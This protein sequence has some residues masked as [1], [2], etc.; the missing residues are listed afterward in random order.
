MIKVVS[1]TGEFPMSFEA[2]DVQGDELVLTGKMGIW[3]ATTHMPATDLLAM[4][5]LMLKPA[6]IWF[7]IKVPFLAL[8]AKLTTSG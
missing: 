3:K 7:M 5:P 1:P 6:V 2:V 8:K 4:L